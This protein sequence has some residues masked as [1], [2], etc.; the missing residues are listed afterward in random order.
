MSNYPKLLTLMLSLSALPPR[1]SAS[2]R[3]PVLS[4]EPW[5]RLRHVAF[6]GAGGWSVLEVHRR[7]L[8]PLDI[9]FP[10]SPAALGVSP[11]GTMIAFVAMDPA[12]HRP[13]LYACARNCEAPRAVGFPEGRH[14]DPL[15]TD[16][17]WIY[18]AHHAGL[19]STPCVDDSPEHR[20]AQLWRVKF[21][22]GLPE[23]LTNEE[24]C[25][26]GEGLLP[27]GS[28]AFIHKRAILDR[29]IEILN[30]TS[31]ERKVVL[32]HPRP[33][34][35]AIAPD[36]NSLLFSAPGFNMV[37]ILRAGQGSP[38]KAV[39]VI[40]RASIAR[41][42]FGASENEVLFQAYQAV[43]LIDGNATLKLG[44]LPPFPPTGR[45]Q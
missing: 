29:K 16:D 11:D 7:T 8:E 12:T 6:G 45:P 5:K 1:A 41:P 2:D 44:D 26:Y 13:G 10:T 15:V 35:L 14:W 3:A 23:R 42:R 20:S 9:R 31:G 43:W 27:D 34:E 19:E 24:G 39:F 36:G 37:T 25:H 28:L 18:F 30:T 40:E 4:I 33:E 22:G 32:A 21:D 17:G 38:A